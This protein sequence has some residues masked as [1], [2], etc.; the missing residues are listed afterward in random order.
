MTRRFAF[1]IAL[2]FAF[3]GCIDQRSAGTSVETESDI[4]ARTLR[5]DS[6][7]PPT[8]RPVDSLTVATL[9]L[10]AKNFDFTKVAPDGR[11]LRVERVDESPIPFQL[12]VWDSQ[13]QVGRIRVRLDSTLLRERARLVLKWG[14]TVQGRRSDSTSTWKG[15]PTAQIHALNSVLVDDFEGGSFSALLPTLP[16]WETDVSD[17]ARIFGI[18]KDTAGQKRSGYALHMTF[19]AEGLE[20]AVVKVPLTRPMRR[21]SLRTLDSLVVWVRGTSAMFTAFEFDNAGTYT[22][23]WHLDT[24]SSNWTRLRIRPSDLD[25]AHA[26][27]GNRPWNEVRDS[28][29]H[30]TFIG[31]RGGDIWL[32]DLRLFG[33]GPDDF[34]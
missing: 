5:V 12:E 3:A 19:Q 32:D 2:A 20:Y 34:Q 17:S 27:G 28:V 26:P 13:A 14:D 30:I 21:V 29:T 25:T 1:S 18:M 10:D 8:N 33:V 31:S 9:L 23:S 6:I 24:L 22:K 15:L 7:L 11:D 4:A 16:A